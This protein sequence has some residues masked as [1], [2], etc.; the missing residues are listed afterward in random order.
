MEDGRG[1]IVASLADEESGLVKVDNGE[2]RS[3]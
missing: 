3:V 1:G 2:T